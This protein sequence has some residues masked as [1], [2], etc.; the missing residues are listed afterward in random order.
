MNSFNSQGIDVF[1]H[2][3]LVD[4]LQQ[5]GGVLID[6]VDNG[7]DQRGFTISTKNKPDGLD[8]GSCGTAEGGCGSET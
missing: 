1:M 5:F 3:S 6:F 7:S 8:C 2:Q 4:Q